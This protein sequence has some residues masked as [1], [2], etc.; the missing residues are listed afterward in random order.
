M[1]VIFF[2]LFS[3]TLLSND[4]A[5][6]DSAFGLLQQAACDTLILLTDVCSFQSS[7]LGQRAELL[8]LYVL[9]MGMRLAF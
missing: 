9:Q 2:Y 8:G 5:V 3:L 6:T 1:V 7:E 4:R